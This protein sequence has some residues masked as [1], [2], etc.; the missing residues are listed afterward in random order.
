MIDIFIFFPRL[1]DLGSHPLSIG[2]IR[3]ISTILSRPRQVNSHDFVGCIQS[4]TIN[5][6]DKLQETPTASAGEFGECPRS[7][8]VDVCSGYSCLNGGNCSSQW[9]GPVCRCTAKYAGSFCEKGMSSS[10]SC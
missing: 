1:L 4:F 3:N 2:G 5:G 9:E 6:E 8:N 10:L 7:S